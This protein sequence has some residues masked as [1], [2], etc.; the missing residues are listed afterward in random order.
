M[1][2]TF[3]RSETLIDTGSGGC[4]LFVWDVC[5]SDCLFGCPRFASE[6]VTGLTYHIL[7]AYY[8]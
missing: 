1:T 2:V 4:T 5:L 3:L 7:L 6:L 8:V